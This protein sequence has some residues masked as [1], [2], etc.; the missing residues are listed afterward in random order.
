M[1]TI[2]RQARPKRLTLQW[3]VSPADPLNGVVLAVGE[4]PAPGGAP[5]PPLGRRR[6]SAPTPPEPCIHQGRRAP[7]GRRGAGAGAGHPAVCIP[8]TGVRGSLPESSQRS[9]CRI[10]PAS[11]RNRVRRACVRTA[12]GRSPPWPCEA[13]GHGIGAFRAR[14][15]AARHLSSLSACPRRLSWP[16][17]KVVLPDGTA[18]SCP[19]ARPAST[20]PARSARAR[21]AGRARQ[22]RRRRATS[23]AAARTAA[24]SRS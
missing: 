4:I 17:M 5:R 2:L 9:C 15:P 19:T 16:P 1:A 22:G 8:P 3:G 21:R 12:P 7:R 20:P 11:Y 10:V 24:A 13:P 18:S 14:G 23:P 6:G